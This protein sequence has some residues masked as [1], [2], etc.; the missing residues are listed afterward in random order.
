VTTTFDFRALFEHAS[1]GMLVVDSTL[2]VTQANSAFAALVGVPIDE[3]LGRSVRALLDAE[4]LA[5]NP[6]HTEA[7]R[8]H[9]SAAAMRRFRSYGT[10]RDIEVVTHASTPAAGTQVKI[11]LPHRPMSTTPPAAGPG[12]RSAPTAPAGVSGRVLLVEDEPRVRAQA[13]R[14]LERCGYSVIEAA[15]GADGEAQFRTHR[16]SVD[17][18]VTDVVMPNLGGLEMVERLRA[19]AARVPIVFVSG[20]TAEDRDLPLDARTA[21]VPK[22]YS[23]GALC[24]AIQMVVAS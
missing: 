7:V 2:R 11:F 22:P 18:V 19:I 8:Q 6:L 20:F 13:R 12:P 23:I 4:D 15:D 21:F 14:L 1:D 5:M 3:L 17:V 24:E 10:L 9:G 16:E